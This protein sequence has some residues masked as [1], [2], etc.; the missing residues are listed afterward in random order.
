M[1]STE[2]FKNNLN[3][4]QSVFVPFAVNFFPDPKLAYKIMSP[5][6]GGIAHTDNICGA[7]TGGLAAIGLHIGHTSGSE[8][9]AK[10]LCAKAAQQFMTEFKARHGSIN[11]TELLGNNMSIPGEREK[12]L[13][14]NKFQTICSKLVESSSD[15]VN[16]IL[17]EYAEDK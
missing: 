11:C 9:E 17:D 15:L 4:A 2:L 10:A 5:F 13:A 12:A 16:K 6:G 1:K 7:V 3:C 8:T 14:A